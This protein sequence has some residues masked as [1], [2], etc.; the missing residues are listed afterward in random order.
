MNAVDILPVDLNLD[1]IEGFRLIVPFKT[2][3]D[4]L[5]RLMQEMQVPA[6]IVENENRILGVIVASRL[7]A[8]LSRP[9]TRELTVRKTISS[10]MSIIDGD[11]LILDH[12]VPVKQAVERALLRGE[13]AYDPI[14][15]RTHSKIDKLVEMDAVLRAQANVLDNANREKDTLIEEIRRSENDLRLALKRLQE[16]QDRLVQSEK[17]ASL[18][19]LVAGIAH[20]INT[21][22]GVALTAASNFG[23][24]TIA[25]TES[26]ESNALKR[27][28]MQRY[29]VLARETSDMIMFNI[30]RAAQLIQSFKQVAVD[31][32]SEHQRSFD[33]NTFLGQ[34]MSSLEPDVRKAGH[35]IV[36][37]C[38][39]GITVDSFPG[40]IGQIMAN[41]VGN[42]VMHAY[43]KGTGGLIKVGGE[44]ETDEKVVLFVQDFGRGMSAEVQAKIYDPFFTTR[45]GTG[46]SG[47]G[48][49]IVFNLVSERLKGSIRCDSVVGQGTR[50]TLSIPRNMPAN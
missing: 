11:P 34:L 28:D 9:F 8:F 40:A 46:G 2:F 35:R 47:L 44:I 17:M 5:H 3:V 7:D 29:M 27:A 26:F 24:R 39:E 45:R 23:E 6:A 33:L 14:I 18:G 43:E 4:D 32:A 21:P 50:F 10:L 25:M 1:A 16:T 49:H 36:L 48:M 19:L 41:L 38:P 20:E 13:R 22:I 37:E 42:A 15:V 12:D 31:Q 30:G